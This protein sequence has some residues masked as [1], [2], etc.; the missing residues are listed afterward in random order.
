MIVNAI[1]RP[2]T[3]PVTKWTGDNKVE[4]EEFYSTALNTP[5]VFTVDE[6][7]QLVR[8][9]SPFGG[10]T[11]SVPEG[12]WFTY[13]FMQVLTDEEFQTQYQIVEGSAPYQFG[14]N[15]TP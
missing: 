3:I 4:L 14:V 6:E 15:S 2:N 5:V 7:G 13:M 8:G 11:P 1:S 10:D 12:M 9:T